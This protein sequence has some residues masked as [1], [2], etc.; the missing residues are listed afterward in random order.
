MLRFSL[1]NK[2]LNKLVENRKTSNNLKTELNQITRS[3]N[4]VNQQLKEKEIALKTHKAQL[5]TFGTGLMRVEFKY[6]NRC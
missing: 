6:C 4:V 3:N 1:K 2:E 5:E